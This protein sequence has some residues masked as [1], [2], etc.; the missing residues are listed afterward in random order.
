MGF[1]VAPKTYELHFEGREYEGL[2]VS[3][4]GLSLGN[5]LEVQRIT[6]LT[7]ETPDET[8]KMIRIFVDSLVSWNLEEIGKDGVQTVPTT[9]DGVGR[10]NIDFV[11]T[12]IGAWLTAIAG[13]PAPLEQNSA[14]GNP[15]LEASMP[16]AVSTESL[17]S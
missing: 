6:S 12:I 17:S 7:Q 2:Q 1:L 8:E 15:S 16:M 11:M 10:L 3:M 4:R 13:V 5:Y 9:R 14:S